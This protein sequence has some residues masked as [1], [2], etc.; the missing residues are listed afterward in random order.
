MCEAETAEDIKAAALVGH[1]IQGRVQ[2]I[3]QR[4]RLEE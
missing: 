2:A 1:V 3:A 4:V